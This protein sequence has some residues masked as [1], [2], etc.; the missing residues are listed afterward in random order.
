MYTSLLFASDSPALEN[1][2]GNF[3]ISL[4]IHEKYYRLSLELV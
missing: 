1:T 4:T 3:I 2:V